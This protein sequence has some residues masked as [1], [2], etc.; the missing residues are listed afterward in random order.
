MKISRSR[1]YKVNVGNYEHIQVSSMVV[2]EGI[3]LFTEEELADMDPEEVMKELREFAEKHMD[4]QLE[5]ELRRAEEVSQAER[6]MLFG[7]PAPER[8]TERAKPRRRST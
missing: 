4:D 7:P 5:P 8:R 3:D 6:S 2:V 1:E